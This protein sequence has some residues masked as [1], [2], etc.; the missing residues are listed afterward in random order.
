M[1]SE[2]L[3]SVSVNASMFL[4]EVCTEPELSEMNASTLRS[5]SRTEAVMSWVALTSATSIGM[6]SGP[7]GSGP[8]VGS[9]PLQ[10]DAGDAGQALEVEADNGVAA[11][12]RVGV[13]L[14]RSRSPAWDRGD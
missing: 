5:T 2:L 7:S 12:R 14:D 6:P 4:S 11:H 1:R 3:F 8:A 13:D 10:A 9:P